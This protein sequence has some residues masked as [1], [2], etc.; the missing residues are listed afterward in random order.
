MLI[1]IVVIVIGLL[2]GII[3]CNTKVRH[4][5]FYH[6]KNELI[7]RLRRWIVNSFD[8][9][10]IGQIKNFTGRAYAYIRLGA[11]GFII[12]LLIALMDKD[13][14]EG[15]LNNIW[16]VITMLMTTY[17]VG[18]L[19]CDGI[20]TSIMLI[21]FRVSVRKEKK[22]LADFHELM[23]NVRF[24][25]VRH[26]LR[27]ISEDTT[28]QTAMNEVK[29]ELQIHKNRDAKNTEN[30]RKRKAVNDSPYF[31]ITSYRNYDIF[32][33]LITQ[34][35]E[36]VEVSEL[37][38]MLL[39][40]KIYKQDDS[41]KKAMGTVGPIILGGIIWIAEKNIFGIKTFLKRYLENAD[42]IKDKLSEIDLDNVFILYLLCVFICLII[43]FILTIVVIFKDKKLRQT[44]IVILEN[45]I[46]IKI[47]EVN[48]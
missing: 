48:L 43:V 34:Y 2:I 14:N 5:S 33:I 32:I 46:R 12:F 28:M 8:I 21:N 24:G 18:M 35:F 6:L 40:L 45:T 17:G 31:Y 3:F 13:I 38:R 44:V 4:L 47:E 37:R 15:G 36:K 22:V 19:I 11:T 26:L 27:N 41:W 23:D 10:N 30:K 25:S 7:K 16:Y 29:F 9:V 39:Y 1:C 20:A 42:W